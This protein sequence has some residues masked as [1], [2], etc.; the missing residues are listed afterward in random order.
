MSQASRLKN[1]LERTRKVSE[2]MLE[3]FQTPEQWTH[4]VH[5]GANHALWF[6][7][8]MCVTDS[9]FLSL[10]A[11]ERAKE[12]DGYGEKF[13]MGSQPTSDPVAYPPA[14]EVLEVMRE[15]RQALL[16]A[17]ESLTDEDLAR[18]TP[19]GTPDMFPDI[20]SIFEMATWHE[21]L[22]AGQ[23]SVARRALGNAPLFGT[24]PEEAETH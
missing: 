3:A 20:A 17:L 12:L 4:Q 13:G 9:F 16:S 23:M 21:G 8:H 15:R 10:V 1:Q 2:G 5:P 22:H 7:G 6:A 14:T 11:P 19:E 24:S 18:P